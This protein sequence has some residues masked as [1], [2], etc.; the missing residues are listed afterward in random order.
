MAVL[1]MLKYP[2]TPVA[3]AEVANAEVRE[4]RT[5]EKEEIVLEAKT[6]AVVREG[7]VE[8]PAVPTLEREE[9]RNEKVISFS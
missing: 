5:R 1:L 2:K 7:T 8:I 4:E 3:V 9:A 6:R